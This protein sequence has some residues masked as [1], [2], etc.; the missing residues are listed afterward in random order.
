MAEWWLGKVCVG[1]CSSM[2]VV[3]QL[4]RLVCRACGRAGQRA[5][6]GRMGISRVDYNAKGARCEYARV[7][8]GWR[9]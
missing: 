8:C 7:V 2:H 3:K 4:G 9:V 1:E 6:G 5:N